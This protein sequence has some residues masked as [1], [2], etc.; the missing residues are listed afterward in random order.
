MK[1]IVEIGKAQFLIV[2]SENG[3]EV[4]IHLD[5][6]GAEFLIET[7]RA[8]MRAPEKDHAHLRTGAWG[9]K[10]LTSGPASAESE[11]IN[12]VTIHYWPGGQEQFRDATKSV[13]GNR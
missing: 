2:E 3:H 10:E 7:I 9:G 6:A 13:D 5:A 12:M 8:L 4:R 1:T 11:L